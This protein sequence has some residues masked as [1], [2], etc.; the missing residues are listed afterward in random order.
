MGDVGWGENDVVVGTSCLLEVGLCRFRS[1]DDV[2][3][4]GA[5]F[6]SFRRSNAASGTGVAYSGKYVA[7]I[8]S[9]SVGGVCVPSSC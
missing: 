5:E 2:S 4:S 3:S 1:V 9:W 6:S 8:S 7:R